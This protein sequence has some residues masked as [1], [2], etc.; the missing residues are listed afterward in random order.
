MQKVIRTRYGQ[1]VAILVILFAI[2]LIRLGVL[3]ILQEEKWKYEAT[4]LSTKRIYTKAPRGE[5]LDRYGRVLANNIQAFSLQI[6]PRDVEDEELNKEALAVY[7][8]LEK[9]NEKIIDNLPIVIND[10]IFRYTFQNNIENWLRENELPITYTAEET[11]EQLKKRYGIYEDVDKYK[12]QEDL[13]NIYKVYPPIS[14]KN[15]VYTENLDKEI[16]LGRYGIDKKTLEEEG[17]TKISLSPKEAFEKIREYFEIDKKYSDEEARAIIVIRNELKS[18]GYRKYL[19]AYVAKNLSPETIFQIKEN[20][21]EF[22]SFDVIPE[23]I[24][25]YPNGNT[26]SHILGYLGKISEHDK[27]Y[28]VDKLEYNANDLI[29]KDGIEEAFESKLKGQDGIKE[30]QVN[31]AGKKVRDIGE[32]K[33]KKG[34]NIY[35]TIDLDLQKTAEEALKRALKEIQIGGKFES[36]Y[37]TYPFRDKYPNAKVGAVVAIEVETGD[38]LAMASYPDFNPNLFVNGINKKDWNA[39]Q[40]ENPRDYMAP[41][42]LYNV[43]T[44]TPVQPGSTFKPITG[45]TAMECGLDPNKKIYTNGVI[46]IGKSKFGC[47]IYNMFGGHHGFINLAE[48][49]EVSCN[50]YFYDVGTGM[51]FSNHKKSL[52]YNKPI[53]VELIK[54]YGEEFGLGLP[55]GIEIKERAIAIPTEK[56]KVNIQKNKLAYDLNVNAEDYF[57]KKVYGNPEKLKKSIQ[58]IVNMIYENPSKVKILEVLNEK[59]LGV[60]PE[61]ADALAD[62]C[63]YTYFNYAGWTLS[64]QFNISIGQGENSYTPLQM[65]NYLATLGNGGVRNKVSLIKAIQNEEPIKKPKGKK[66]K[67]KDDKY[68]DEV[69]KGMRRVASGS[70]GSLR[71]SFSN[72]PVSVAAKTGTAERDGKMHPPDETVYIKKYLKYIN[73]KLNWEQVEAEMNR[74]LADEK[75]GFRTKDGAVRQAVINLSGEGMNYSK[76]DAYKSDY[77]NFAWVIAMAPAENPKIAVAVMLVQGGNSLYAGPIAREVIAK[78]LQLDKKYDDFSSKTEIE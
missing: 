63:K 12:A 40:T 29:G 52:G 31:V 26:A 23:S 53:N 49:L 16:F 9:N 5:I 28:Y 11:F 14:V 4:N 39:L 22:P 56:E 17:A 65:A 54:H 74:I 34:N 19:P 25:N 27:P 36:K 67:L 41:A 45:I 1:I 10:G 57:V 75:Q 60:K 35:L 24:R 3:T 44:R 69:I 58:K 76:I 46:P 30:V 47:F 37:G 38:V 77:D 51:D 73:P 6:S 70:R 61:K 8:I 66:V 78:Y 64:D 50:Y 15:M 48:A 71:G 13:Q 59:G 2:L 42:P 72:F 68:I 18:M 43:A 33:Q 7:K 55:T 32:I 62:L 21:L 20:S